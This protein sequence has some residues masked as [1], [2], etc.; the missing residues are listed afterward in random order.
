MSIL[1]RLI[2][3]KWKKLLGFVIWK[4][5]IDYMYAEIITDIYAYMNHIADYN[6]RK[7]LISWL[8]FLAFLFLG[9]L[10]NEGM[11]K[12][13]Y[14]FLLILSLIPTL[15]VWWVR[16]DD[17]K[18]M[19]LVLLYWSVWGFTSILLSKSTIYNIH[20][21][22]SN[23]SNETIRED[24]ID[25]DLNLTA[26]MVMFLICAVST[27]YFSYRYGG[28]RLF[29]RLGDVYNYRM[30][31]G[32]NMSSLGAYWYN[33]MVSI[34]MPLILLFYIINKK[35]IFTLLCC[36]L[37][38]M[39]YS[40]YGNKAML[41]MIILTIC[42]S[43]IHFTDISKQL[44][45]YILL[46][47][48]FATFGSCVLEKLQI[49]GWGVALVNRMT[50]EIATGHFYYYDFFQNHPLLLLRQSVLR[51]LGSDP[52]GTPIGII[53]GSDSKYN[54]SGNY[55]NF[56]NGVFSDAYANFG[57]IGVVIYPILFVVSICIFEIMLSDVG[58]VYK[59]LILCWLLL[60][61]MSI[62]Y[63]QWLVSGGF[64]VAVIILRVYKHYKI[65]IG[66]R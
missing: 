48:N 52:Y 8:C 6:F 20:K 4:C 41:F 44:T 58:Q 62:G 50:T 1:S 43:I 56:N 15:T 19:L 64:V 63:F 45:N 53:I 21:S 13:S 31:E 23:F 37:I 55:N 24:E 51:F 22:I 46:G 49:T 32:N 18:C 28:M 10:I 40:I 66:S 42:I 57:V 27:L 14:D 9:T 61:C 25:N 33:W 36:L 59:Y 30:V 7:L 5:L 17:T 65:R 29:V 35:H 38:S 11:I 34:V 2:E 26:I 16:N 12:F 54:L 47:L 39:N 3:G 60:Y